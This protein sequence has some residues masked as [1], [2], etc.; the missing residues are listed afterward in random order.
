VLTIAVPRGRG[1]LGAFCAGV[2]ALALSGCHVFAIG[3]GAAAAGG[4]AAVA[5]PPAVSLFS[6]ATL[7]A[8]AQLACSLQGYANSHA[9]TALSIAAGLGCLW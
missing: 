6:P 2:S 9:D 4:T 8:A 1:G 3:A 7:S 5:T